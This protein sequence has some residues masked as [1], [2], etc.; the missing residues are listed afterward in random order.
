MKIATWN[1]NSIVARLPRVIEWLTSNQPAVLCLQE[2]KIPDDRFPID[3]FLEA[4]Y[5]IELFGEA[6][7]NGVAL[8]SKEKPVDVR[9]GFPGA[10][11]TA[12]RRFIRARI[13]GVTLLNVYVPNGQFV[14]SDKY[15]FKLNWLA[16]LRNYLEAECD[17]DEPFVLCGDFNIAPEDRDVYNPLLWQGR[18]LFSEPEKAALGLIREWGFIDVVRKHH[19]EASLYS[20]WDYRAGAFRRNQGLRI[21]HMWATGALAEKCR[22]AWIDKTT[23][24]LERP[25]DHAPVVADFEL[26]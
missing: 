2:T 14:G 21:D 10:G 5:N 9:R 1:I 13:G 11:E 23:R 8:I 24:S 4:G 25:S 12:P 22:A 15:E 19:D 7:Y 17:P 16:S 20:W 26:D 3:P 18:V 6:T